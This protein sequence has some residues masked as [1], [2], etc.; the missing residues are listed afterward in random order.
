M[1]EEQQKLTLFNRMLNGIK[2]VPETV[3]DKGSNL[4]ENIMFGREVKEPES[5]I[6][7]KDGNV[8][9]QTGINNGGRKG[10]LVG[11]ASDVVGGA[12]ENMS[13]SF[14]PRNLQLN[15]KKGFGYRLGEGL[16]SAVRLLD[17]PLVR[18]AVAYG[19][20][21]HMGD[22]NPLEQGLIAT[23]TNIQNK[24]ADRVYR[25]QLK[26]LGMPA[27]EVDSIR[28][29]ITGDTYKNVA[30]SYKARWNKANLGDLAAFNPTIA[31]VLKQNPALGN[32]YLPSSV[33][34]AIL[35]GDLTEAQ[36]ANLLSQ[37]SHRKVM[38]GVAQQNANTAKAKAD[39][40]I[41]LN[42]AI[43]GGIGTG[44]PVVVNTGL[45]VQ[46]TVA[47]HRTNAF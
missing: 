7:N 16:G 3:I 2:Q 29:F 17:N 33:A 30:D 5:S 38:G 1:N 9:I 42:D 22:S 12:K 25:N 27:E 23:S 43:T 36:I 32:T 15:D 20:S 44:Q 41:K 10:G 13:N 46:P 21:K 47:G 4:Y 19:L 39:S 45:P 40:Q 31:E 11:F 6:E 35:K 8:V 37:V 28:G 24:S 34:T 18:G 14:S 26:D